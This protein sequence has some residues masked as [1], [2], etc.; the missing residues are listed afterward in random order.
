M[1]DFNWREMPWL[2]IGFS[3]KSEAIDFMPDNTDR[4]RGIEDNCFYVDGGGVVPVLDCQLIVRRGADMT[5]EEFRKAPPGFSI[6]KDMRFID[7]MYLLSIG[8]Y[9]FPWP[10]DNSVIQ[11]GE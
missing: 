5:D 3:V 7:I 9:P 11:E 10:S 8:V 2:F 6:T 4:I 1:T